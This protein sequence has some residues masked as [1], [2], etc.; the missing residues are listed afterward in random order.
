M[1]KPTLEEITGIFDPEG[2]GYDTETALEY[3]FKP[4][5]TG[6]WQSRIPQTGLLLK[7]RGHETW[8]KTVKG[9]EDAGYEIYKGKD[10]RYYSR[11]RKP[12]MEEITGIGLPGPPIT[13]PNVTAKRD[14]D[15]VDLSEDV[16]LPVMDVYNSFE[17]MKLMVDAV[18]DPKD[19]IVEDIE[20]P[21]EKGLQP[22]L[23]AREEEKGLIENIFGFRYPPKPSNWELASPIEK[24]N[25][26]MLPVSDI[27]GRIGGKI[28]SDWRMT[29]KEEVRNLMA[30]D[31]DENLKTYQKSPEMVGWT[32]EKIAE[33]FV[34]K[35]VFKFSGLHRVLTTAGEKAAKPF[36]MKSIT[37]RGGLQT[38]KTM[39]ASGLKN[40]TR[41]S[42]ITFLRAAPENM[43]FI[44]SWSA[45][46][47]VMEGQTIKGVG[48]AAAKGAGWG[49]GLTAG[50][51][52]LSTLVRTPEIALIFKK[53]ME[54]LAK[55]YPKTVDLLGKKIPEEI[56]REWMRQYRVHT[57]RDIRIIDLTK[58]QRAT[59]RNAVRAAE[60]EL[61]KRAKYEQAMRTYWSTEDRLA[62]EAAKG[63]I[64]K[65][66]I[67]VPITPIEPKVVSAMTAS[68]IAKE[69]EVF[70]T[71]EF[72]LADVAKKRLAELKKALPF[73]EGEVT[74]MAY[75][76]DDG[77]ILKDMDATSH[78]D[79]ARKVPEGKKVVDAGFLD[80]EGNYLMRDDVIS[81]GKT[82]PFVDV[83]GT[84]MQAKI[85][86]D[87]VKPEM[88]I[89]GITVELPDGT[90]N[91][92]REQLLKPVEQQ[93]ADRIEQWKTRKSSDK[94]RGTDY[95]GPKPIL[96]PY[97]PPAPAKPVPV[98]PEQIA[99]ESEVKY[100]PIRK[101]IEDEG[102]L[103]LSDEEF[104]AF[105]ESEPFVARHHEAGMAAVP[106]FG[107]IKDTYNRAH[108]WIFTFGEA[109]RLHPELYDKLMKSYGRRNAG[110]EKAI[111]EVG[112]ILT[113]DISLDEDLIL[114]TTYED[115]RLKPPEE[116]KEVYGK[117]SKLLDR[118]EKIQIKEGI[119]QRPFQERMIEEN[120]IRIEELKTDLKHPT[121]SKRLQELVAENEELRNMRYLSHSIVARRAIESKT[122][123]LRGDERKAFM[124]RMSALYRKR[125][126][127][128]FLKDY[129]ES[130]LLNKEDIRMSRLATQEVADYYMRSSYKSI[131]DYG[132]EQGLIKP[133]SK[134]LREL[135]WLNQRELGIV[136]P[137]AKEQLFHPL[138]GSAL[139]ELKSMRMGRGSLAQQILGMVKQGQ[140][141]KPS[142][143]WTY[144]AVQKY[145]KG[146]YSLDPTKEAKYSVQA[147]KEVLNKSPLY[148]KLNAD[149][150]YQ[151]PYE[152]SRGSREEQIELFIRQNSKEINKALKMLEKTT[153]MSWA[154][155]DMDLGKLSKNMLMAG[156][157]AI[158]QV[159]WTGDKIQ[160]TQSYLIL[161]D[162][163]YSHDEAI[164]VASQSHGAYSMLSEKYKKRLSPIL[165]VYSF[166]FLMPREM[167]K[168]LAEP[169]SE[170]PKY[171][172]GGEKIPKEKW[173]RWVKA[174]VGAVAIPLAID[175]YMKHRGFK[176]EGAHLGPLAWKWKKDV[177]VDGKKSE[178]VV[179][180]NDILNMPIKYWQRLTYYNPIR[181]ESRPTQA[182]MNLIKWEIHPVYRIFFWDIKENRRSFGSGT[183]VYDPS[184]NTTTQLAQIAKYVFGQSFRF[185]GGMM[186]AMGEGKM[187]EKERAEQEKIFDESLTTLDKVLFT[188]LGYKYTR[189][190]LKDRQVIMAKYL[191]KELASRRFN[192]ERR[193]EGEEKKRR[194]E[195]LK[196]W[197]QKCQKW[198]MEDMK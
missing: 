101:R 167:Y 146:I 17:P 102:L 175:T 51:S 97:Q 56:E 37:A 109:K 84:V 77:T 189:Q 188:A 36:V 107:V 26:A 125:K 96:K 52:V 123:R 147:F 92:E 89:D 174:W 179:G 142:I 134:E 100:E 166:R 137:E 13:D 176:K 65:E 121:K 157:R 180:V 53:A 91:I 164:K 9:E 148:H 4:D 117:F 110:V 41:Q 198:I 127:K 7:G 165:F 136:A 2:S 63:A 5:E 154:P 99:K 124:S 105:L 120:N 57:G 181:P 115:K 12:T 184:A 69:I 143:I 88:F 145:M 140:F 71:S 47:A 113:E 74:G 163:G 187:T 149:N 183:E 160:R 195:G 182:V 8:H 116:L 194:I 39:S 196:R 33:Y 178:V 50:L 103:A 111:D 141:I 119:F 190:N 19:V 122:N 94:A 83:D 98:E 129:L 66:P 162:M 27:L 46:D 132:K 20:V 59:F 172:K 75:L 168:I 153:D 158:A 70:E 21:S 76:L 15:V 130:G 6:H 177:V 104:E 60:K 34:L 138:M 106:D 48:V 150:L 23:V 62:R 3:G 135:G 151:F 54:S 93:L 192:I 45:L 193:Y 86:E 114:A 171:V 49:A 78:M 118:L 197:A 169:L 22:V 161:K 73:A 72:A 173:N 79:L 186:D 80:A 82:Y 11:K 126:G 43:A 152:V 14:S 144:N 191:Q 42:L 1:P 185:Y 131:Y 87:D 32:A 44:A 30:G 133:E 40:L 90:F 128:L 10:G 24:F 170:I 31:Y 139:A 58:T 28:T 156:H 18:Q 81:K 38:L 85:V 61:L 35:S 25:F 67:T 16:D 64:I 55:K 155:E 29:T 112:K 108:D 95:A 68:E 159:T